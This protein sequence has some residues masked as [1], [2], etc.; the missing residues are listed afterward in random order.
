[1]WNTRIK[2][3]PLRDEH[4]ALAEHVRVDGAVARRGDDLALDVPQHLLQRRPGD[5]PEVAVAEVVGCCIKQLLGNHHQRIQ[6][7]NLIY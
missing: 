5:P 3:P 2:S 4:G 6:L 1:M 7:L